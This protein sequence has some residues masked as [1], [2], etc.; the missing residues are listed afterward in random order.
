MKGL[1]SL[2]ILLRQKDELWVSGQV[3]MVGCSEMDR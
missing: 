3:W 1:K 2:E